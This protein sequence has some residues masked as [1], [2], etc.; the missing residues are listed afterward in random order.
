MDLFETMGWRGRAME[1]G[2][3][4]AKFYSEHR[5]SYGEKLLALNTRIRRLAGEQRHERIV[6]GVGRKL[7][8]VLGGK[9]EED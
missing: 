6:E 1:I 8:E 2:E 9:N 5:S 7:G 4:A 3:R